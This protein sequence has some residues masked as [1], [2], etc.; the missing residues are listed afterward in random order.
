MKKRCKKTHLQG[1]E[2]NKK[3][4][5]INEHKKREDR[6]PNV[7]LKPAKKKNKANHKTKSDSDLEFEN[8]VEK[9]WRN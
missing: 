1:Q 3:N 6:N 4:K 9:Y 7:I 5:S 8:K 2:K